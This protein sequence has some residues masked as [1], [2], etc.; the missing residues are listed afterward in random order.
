[1]G[2]Q[3][4]E[5]CNSTFELVEILHQDSFISNVIVRILQPVPPPSRAASVSAFEALELDKCMYIV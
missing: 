5:L 3:S 2:L 4:F 1:M